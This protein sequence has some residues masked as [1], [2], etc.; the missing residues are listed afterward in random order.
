ME[1]KRVESFEDLVVWQKGMALAKAVY[2]LTGKGPIE[3]DYGLRDQ[4]RRAA[5]SVPANVAEG[6][7][8]HTRKDYLHYLYIAKGSAGEVRCLLRIAHDIGYL[9]PA[10]FAQLNSAAIEVSRFLGN[11]IKSLNEVNEKEGGK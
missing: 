3:R 8:R 10:Q 7:E 5:V 6:F 1:R 4:L 2:E 9:N 11:L